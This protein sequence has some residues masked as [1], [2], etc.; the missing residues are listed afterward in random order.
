MAEERLAS[1]DR[2]PE[3]LV[4]DEGPVRII[5]LN[6]PDRANALTPPL[7][8]AFVEALIAAEEDANVRVVLIAAS[9][10]AFCGGH[11][12]KARAEADASGV[13]TPAPMRGTRRYFAEVLLES[14][15]PTIAAVDGAAIGAGFEIALACDMRVASE[16]ASF[17]LPEA[18]RGLGAQFGIALLPR[19]TGS[20]LAFE[21]LY[22][23]DRIDARRARDAGLLNRLVPAGEALGAALD[24]AR[25]VA[26]NAP[27]SLRRIKENMVRAS[28][29]PLSLA[30]RLNEGASP[31]ESEDRAEG[32]RAFLEKREPVWNGR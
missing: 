18:K 17:A 10:K 29:V 22:T 30:L 23:G 25:A 7:I 24:L 11:D 4:R 19:V 26:A 3:L 1:S 32:M 14:W 6:R 16:A 31:Y 9:G 27:M 2:P 15:K 20:A 12:L 8:D 5:T 13:R 21:A 28:G